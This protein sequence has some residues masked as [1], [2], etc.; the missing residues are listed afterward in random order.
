[1]NCTLSCERNSQG[2][3]FLYNLQLSNFA[4]Y[5]SQV[6]KFSIHVSQAYS[7]LD[8]KINGLLIRHRCDRNTDR[9]NFWYS[10][11]LPFLLKPCLLYTFLFYNWQN[12]F[13]VCYRNWVPL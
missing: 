8:S 2:V 12:P 4:R 6:R 10:I 13:L 3:S 5:C 9:C 7:T 11:L 1:M